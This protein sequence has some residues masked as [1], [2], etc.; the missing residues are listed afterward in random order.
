MVKESLAK[1][2][3]TRINLRD[4]VHRVNIR[5]TIVPKAKTETR[6]TS[7]MVGETRTKT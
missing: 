6:T 2:N 4:L 3:V 7:K 5:Q 1:M